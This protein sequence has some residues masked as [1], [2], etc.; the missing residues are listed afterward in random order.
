MITGRMA[1]PL[2]EILPSNAVALL[3]PLALWSW[4]RRPRAWAIVSSVGVGLRSARRVAML[5]WPTRSSVRPYRGRFLVRGRLVWQSRQCCTGHAAGHRPI[6]FPPHLDPGPVSC[7]RRH[8]GT[9]RGHGSPG[10]GVLYMRGR[11]CARY[12]ERGVEEADGCVATFAYVTPAIATC[13]GGSCRRD[14]GAVTDRR[15]AGGADERRTDL[16]AVAP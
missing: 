1:R 10:S 4:S 13:W 8:L 2:L 5:V 9:P 12:T 15:H 16:A 11:L 6:A 14:A 3:N 7:R